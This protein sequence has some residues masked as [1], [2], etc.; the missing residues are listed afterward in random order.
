MPA[1]ANGSG[2]M[3]RHVLLTLALAACDPSSTANDAGSDAAMRDARP[4]PP[5]PEEDG[6]RIVAREPFPDAGATPYACEVGVSDERGDWAPLTA[7]AGV[8]IGGSVP[9]GGTGQAGLVAWLALRIAGID[10]ADAVFHAIVQMVLVN[11]ATGVTADNKQ[12][13]DPRTFEC[14]GD[15][16]CDRATVL[17]EISHLAK[18]PELE[19]TT[20]DVRARALDADDPTRVLCQASDVGVLAR[21]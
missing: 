3:R 19:G 6:G 17:V 12:W 5:A 15:G 9:I 14:H 13:L 2:N 7:S 20:V 8:S 4:R 11:T 21:R 18:L 16:T 10:P 1:L